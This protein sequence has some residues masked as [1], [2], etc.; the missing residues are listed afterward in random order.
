[1]LPGRGARGILSVAVF[2]A[3]EPGTGREILEEDLVVTVPGPFSRSEQLEPETQLVQGDLGARY[4]GRL[5]IPVPRCP[6]AP[7]T[8]PFPFG[9]GCH[10]HVHRPGMLW[11]WNSTPHFACAWDWFH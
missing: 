7:V 1:M 10:A 9:S 11:L 5:G 3:R 2:A 8:L 4:R 6:A